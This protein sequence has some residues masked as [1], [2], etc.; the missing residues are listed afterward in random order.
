MGGVGKDGHVVLRRFQA[1]AV[2]QEGSHQS[3]RRYPT[4]REL[5]HMSVQ[6]TYVLSD[7]PTFR[8][9]QSAAEVVASGK[10]GRGADQPGDRP[11]L[12]AERSPD[13]RAF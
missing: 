2:A 6:R 11:C 8:N 10:Q 9:R 13:P 1:L 12:V 4:L 5:I 7:P 3:R